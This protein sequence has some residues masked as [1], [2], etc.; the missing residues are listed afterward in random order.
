MIAA[1]VAAC[2]AAFL[3][4]RAA[5]AQTCVRPT[6]PAGARGF[7]YGAATPR[8]FGNES[9]LVWYAASG[10]HAVAPASSR[11]DGVPDAVADVAEVTRDALARFATMGFR[12]P[13][14]D[15][16]NPAC[17]SN[18]GDGRLDVYLFAMNGA[19]GVTSAEEGR[20]EARRCA[21]FIIAQSRFGAPYVSAAA[22]VRTVLP[23]ETFHA[24]QNAYHV[25]LDRFWAE[26]TAQ[27]AAATLDPTLGD[28]E[29]FLPAY[30]SQASRALDAPA[31]GVTSSFLYGSAVWPVFLGERYGV[32]TIR[33][34]LEA[35]AAT[36]AT[37]ALAAADTALRAR[38]A[39]LAEAFTTFA[40][41]N[42]GAGREGTVGGYAAGATYPQVTVA[43]L[44]GAASG[45]TSGNA[46]FYYRVRATTEST[47]TLD[48]D[49]ARNAGMLIPVEDGNVRV[50]RATPLPATFTGEAIVAVAGFT[51]SKTDAPFELVV[52]APSGGCAVA[53]GHVDP[54][55]IALLAL[56]ALLRRRG[57]RR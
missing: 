46:A 12:A 32:D 16:L 21:G 22:G 43:E 28:L 24:V 14:S 19:D 57:T 48:T 20:C 49:P 5:A 38:G 54:R 29:H 9:V 15:A 3:L 6:D 10:A 36:P 25:E 56:A 1:R 51:P 52:G 27:W 17:G 39:S 7:A 53:G 18:G 47:A 34:V 44:D 55:A 33:A 31:N 23:H 50:D 30:F 40:T 42:A 4:A 35:E 2:A 26:G 37:T 45:I 41:W 8:S 13:V 11:A